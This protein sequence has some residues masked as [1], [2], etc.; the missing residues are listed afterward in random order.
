MGNLT[1]ASIKMSNSPGSAPP[2]PTLGL[3]IDRCIKMSVSNVLIT[4]GGGGLPYS[5]TRMLVISL[6]DVN[7]RF[8]SHS[9]CLGRKGTILTSPLNP[10]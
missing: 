8:W 9:G 4:G 1:L 5:C 3:N 10:L 2:P 6:R 7:R